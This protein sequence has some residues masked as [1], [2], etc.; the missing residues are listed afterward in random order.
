MTDAVVEAVARGCPGVQTVFL[1]GCEQATGMAVEAL[2]ADF[3]NEFVFEARGCPS[4][5]KV[6]LS[7]CKRVTDAAVKALAWRC[8]GMQILEPSACRRWRLKLRADF[9]T[10]EFHL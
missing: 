1:D 2:R 4:L 5:Q 8:P 6:Q 9:P 7:G 3:S 10:L